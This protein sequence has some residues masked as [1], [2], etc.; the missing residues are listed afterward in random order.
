M[1][2]KSLIAGEGVYLFLAIDAFEIERSDSVRPKRSK[3]K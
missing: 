2:L 1:T 3:R